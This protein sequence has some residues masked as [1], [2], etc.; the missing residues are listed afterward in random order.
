MKY[1]W[2]NYTQKFDNGDEDLS[3]NITNMVE[4]WLATA[5]AATATI[6]SE[7]KDESAHPDITP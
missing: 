2:Y 4:D 1:T 7:E 3:I 6:T 5:V